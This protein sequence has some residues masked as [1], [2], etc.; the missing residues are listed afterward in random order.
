MSIVLGACSATPPSTAT[1][2]P[3][4]SPDVAPTLTVALAACLL[5]PQGG[6]ALEDVAALE[7][8]VMVWL[9]DNVYADR[10]AVLGDIQGMRGLYRQLGE[11]E[12]FRAIARDAEVMATW[13]DHDYG[14]NDAG[15]E[16]V[17]KD[18]ARRE[19]LDFWGDGA[20]D[21][22]A[23]QPGVYSSQTYGFGHQSVQIILLDNRYNRD[24]Y[25]D[26]SDRTI[27]GAEQWLWL[28]ERLQ[29]PATIRIIGSGIQVVNDYSQWESWGDMPAER[30][31][32]YELIRELD[33]PGVILVSGDM[34]HAELSRH[35]NDAAAFGYP[36]Y[37]LT[38]SGLDQQEAEELPNP[39]RI[40]PIL[41]TDRKF[42]SVVIEWDEDPVI[43]LQLHD[44]AAGALHLDHVVRLSQLQPA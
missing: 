20:A 2:L 6:E 23:H 12:R 3:T 37:D 35:P 14:R 28:R 8:D 33:V 19:F 7:P 16:W 44:A 29:E 41:N 9:G 11:N 10:M 42:G 43:R 4:G 40:G 1:D 26:E 31:R 17:F 5:D 13:D 27:L 22:R 15:A 24:P 32:L 18:A 21:A 30:E 39:S 38:A 36:T 34:H 25:G